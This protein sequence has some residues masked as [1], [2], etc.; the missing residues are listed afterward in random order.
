MRASGLYDKLPLR[1]LSTKHA[2]HLRL[3]IKKEVRR[4]AYIEL[5]E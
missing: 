2:S 4:Y 5:V 1:T 3:E